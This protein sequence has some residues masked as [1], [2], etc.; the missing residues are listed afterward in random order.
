MSI[1]RIHWPTIVAAPSAATLFTNDPVSPNQF[2]RFLR[3]FCMP[4][5]LS[6]GSS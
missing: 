2:F 4:S 5:W 1:D 3:F 6:L